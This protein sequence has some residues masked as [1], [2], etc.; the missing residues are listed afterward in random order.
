MTEE[1]L[2]YLFGRRL[3]LRQLP[4]GHHRAGTDTVL[5]AAAAPLPAQGMVID[6]GCGVGTVGIAVA[7][8][9]PASGITLVDRDEDSLALA[10]ENIRRNRVADRAR[11]VTADILGPASARREAGLLPNT[12]ALV[13]TNPPFAEAARVRASPNASRR[14]AHVLPDGGLEKWIRTACDL[15]MPGGAMVIIHRA[16][17]LP[18]I[19]RAMEKRFGAIAVRPILPRQG[20][21]SHRVLVRGIRGSRAPFAILPPLVLHE[22]DGAL[23]SHAAAIHRGETRIGW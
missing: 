3:V 11:I 6:L 22:A 12:A 17:A 4:K 1:S 18:D 14:H 7:L 19:L 16:D 9:D 2:D 23:T 21:A 8:F 5:L 20:E 15:L 13:L 10:A